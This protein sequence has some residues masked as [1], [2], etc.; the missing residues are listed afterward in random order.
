MDEALSQHIRLSDIIRVTDPRHYK[1]HLACGNQDGIHPLDEYVANRDHWIGW[2][3]WRGDKNDWTRQFIYS[4]IEFY[5]ISNAYLFGGIF[6]VMERLP[7]RYVIR[8]IKE[9]SK[10][11]GRLICRFYRYQGLRGRAFL[12][13]GQ[14]DSFEVLQILPQKYDGERFCGYDL[15]N[16]PFSVL[17]PILQIEK[18]DWKAALTAVKGIY[19]IMDTSNGMSYVGSAYGE[20][21]IWSRLACYLNTGH[22][23]ND[24]LVRTILEK[25]FDYAL[26]NFRFSIL[27]VFAFNTSDEKILEREGHWKNVLLTRQY[28]YNRN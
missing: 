26:T 27:E 13:E 1:L 9:Y 24:E 22:G 4:F 16:H 11:E 28:G 25:G 8:E 14:I 17:R 3:E 5:P 7:D 15:V 18:Q 12:L 20:A 10:W 6:E 21:G 2:N 23:W 19:L